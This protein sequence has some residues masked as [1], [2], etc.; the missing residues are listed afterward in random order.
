MKTLSIRQ[1]RSTL[2]NLDT[3]V[4]ESGEIII[5]RRGK[6]VARVLPI[7]GSRPRPSH[8]ELRKS[9]PRL[10]STSEDLISAER[11]ER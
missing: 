2:G 3:L 7:A 6:P 8:A 11:D 4:A 10:K 5:T 1:M 9:M